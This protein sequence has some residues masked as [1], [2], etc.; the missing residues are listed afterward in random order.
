MTNRQSFPPRLHL[1]RDDLPNRPNWSGYHSS[2]VMIVPSKT[3]MNEEWHLVTLICPVHWNAGRWGGVWCSIIVRQYVPTGKHTHTMYIF[4]RK[5]RSTGPFVKKK[6]TF[7]L[8]LNI[9]L[10]EMVWLCVDGSVSP[11]LSL[12]FTST[13]FYNIYLFCC[14]CLLACNHTCFPLGSKKRE[15]DWRRDW[16][17]LIVWQR[18]NWNFLAFR[19]V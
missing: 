7:S 11:R 8:K 17:S 2:I 3:G 4:N 1:P 5:T 14:V 19:L 6:T 16:T 13:R 10:D 18:K 12:R 15:N 9:K